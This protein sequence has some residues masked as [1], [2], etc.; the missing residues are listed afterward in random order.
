MNGSKDIQRAGNIGAISQELVGPMSFTGLDPFAIGYDAD[1]AQEVDRQIVGPEAVG[2]TLAEVQADR[3][4]FNY[5]PKIE[6]QRLRAN[7]PFLSILPPP[8]LCNTVIFGGGVNKVSVQ[9]PDWAE[10]MTISAVNVAPLFLSFQRE[11]SG[12]PAGP[13]R[14][15]VTPGDSNNIISIDARQSAVLYNVSRVKDFFA[16]GQDNQY[17]YY[18]FYGS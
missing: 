1:A 12:Y 10:L 5:D 18:G 9:I 14:G 4:A 11:I 8:R 16:W 2:A 17:M 6:L 7:Y 3:D 15:Y 13:S